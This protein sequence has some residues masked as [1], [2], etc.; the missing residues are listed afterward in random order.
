M[1][2][3]QS[4]NEPHRPL[5]DRLFPLA[6]MGSLAVAVLAAWYDMQPVD[7]QLILVDTACKVI[8][9]HGGKVER[10]EG[11]NLCVMRTSFREPEHGRMAQVSVETDSG[12]FKVELPTSE[13]VSL[14]I[15]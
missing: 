10:I 4:N 6:F 12:L 3:Q 11:T 13:I 5:D 7:G 2:E 8:K 1:T 15:R 14:A 9:Y